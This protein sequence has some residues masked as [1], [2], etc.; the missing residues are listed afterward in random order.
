M[1]PASLAAAEV[2]VPPGE[3]DCVELEHAESTADR[4]VIEANRE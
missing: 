4:S 2:V 3:N 1:E